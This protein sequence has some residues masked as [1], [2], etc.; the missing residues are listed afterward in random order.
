MRTLGEV[1][2]RVATWQEY[3]LLFTFWLH[4]LVAHSNL[5]LYSLFALWKS[6]IHR[7]LTPSVFKYFQL[8][9]CLAPIMM[10]CLCARVSPPSRGRSYYLLAQSF[11]LC[12]RRCYLR[13]MISIC[14]SNPSTLFFTFPKCRSPCCDDDAWIRRQLCLKHRPHN[15]L[16]PSLPLSTLRIVKR[17]PSEL[18]QF[19]LNLVFLQSHVHCR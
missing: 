16:P 8:S 5:F 10:P 4:A 19:N 6:E 14:G 2:R 9:S 17:R 7:F 11:H 15:L 12:L 3:F 18:W 1:G 13:C